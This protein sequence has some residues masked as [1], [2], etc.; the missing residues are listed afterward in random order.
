MNHEEQARGIHRSGLNCS[1][2]VD[3]AFADIN[4][5]AGNPPAPR[6]IAGKCGALLAAQKVLRDL[7][8]GHEAD[9]E[10]AFK[11]E[12]GY[13]T[14]FDLKR[15]RRNCNDCVGVAARLVDEYLG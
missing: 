6:S 15:N 13:V 11:S 7:G 14:C 12:L 3:R 8:A 5:S 2:S 1:N 10:E 9:L 4:G